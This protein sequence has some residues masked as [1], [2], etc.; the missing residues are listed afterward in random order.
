M[1]AGT[2][3]LLGILATLGFLYG[4]QWL[5]ARKA[6]ALEGQGVPELLIE[7]GLAD[8]GLL[9]FH[10]PT[11]GPCRAMQPHVEAL[12]AEGRAHIVDVSVTPEIAVACGVLG[13]PTT[14]AI[15]D[16]RIVQVVPGVVPP[17]ALE[18]MLAG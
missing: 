10:S 14:I 6:R 5:T 15:A 3:L 13:T 11:C 4:V 17:A 2:G 12:A 7:R 8:D 18:G 1:S 9:W 16:R